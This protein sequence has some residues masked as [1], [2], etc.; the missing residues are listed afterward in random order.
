VLDAAQRLSYRPNRSASLLAK[1]RRHLLG[2]T[3]DLRNAFHADLVEDLHAAAEQR[4][5]DVVLSALTRVRGEELA[6]QTLVDFRCE[7]L[8]L[9]GPLLPE[10]EL[11]ALAQQRPVVV[12]GRR[13]RV[14]GVAVVRT[15]D[16]VGV[17]LGVDHLTGLGHRQI[18]YIDGGR[19][20]IA[21]DRRN[22][23]RAAMRRNGLTA[24]ADVVPGDQSEASGLRA[25]EQLLAEHGLPTALVAYNDRC[26]SGLLDA[27]GRAG[28]AVPAALSIVGYDDSSLARLAHVNLTTV[29]QDTAAQAEHAVLAAVARLDGDGD[30]EGNGGRDGGNSGHREVV[31]TPQLVVRGT[32]SSAP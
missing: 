20:K 5:Y 30:W 3:M 19:G 11:A 8:I 22:G 23:Y 24:M 7:A 6:V 17:G 15:A 9:L 12:V 4:G 10:R 29:R 2:I 25:A 16:D 14:P 32:T 18:T 31:L 28:V 21:A 1:R 13:V 27:F 26:A